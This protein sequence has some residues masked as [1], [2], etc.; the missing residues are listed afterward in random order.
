MREK[1]Q[2]RLF[3]SDK[4][5]LYV[6]I[7]YG[8]VVGM[9]PMKL[10]HV[11]HC[12]TSV[13]DSTGKEVVY[14]GDENGMIH[15]MESGTGFDGEPIDAFFELAFNNLKNSIQLKQFKNTVLEVTGGGYSEFNFSYRI[16]YGSGNYSQAASTNNVLSLQNVSWGDAGVQWGQTYTWGGKAL[17]PI[18]L[19]LGGTAENISMKFSMNSDYYTPA[20]FNGTMLQFIKR[21]LKR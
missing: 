16:G 17:L 2:Y 1:N 21:R 20:T 7:Q 15:Q 3:F 10:A 12:I 19:D 9:M 6:T 4:T 13:E 14:F 11:V 8:K 5:A 18:R